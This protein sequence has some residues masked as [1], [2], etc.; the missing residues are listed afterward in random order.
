[1]KAT[2]AAV[3][4]HECRCRVDQRLIAAWIE[5]AEEDRGRLGNGSKGDELESVLRNDPDDQ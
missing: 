3:S 2:R 4:D 1:M 5:G